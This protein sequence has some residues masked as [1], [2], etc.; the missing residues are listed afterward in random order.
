MKKDIREILNYDIIENVG[1][2]DIKFG[3]KEE[4]FLEIYSLGSDTSHIVKESG[5]W[6]FDDS[7]QVYFNQ[8]SSLS[9]ISL[10][11]NFKGKLNGKI[12][13]GSYFG[14]LRALRKDIDYC[15]DIEGY[16]VGTG[17]SRLQINFDENEYPGKVVDGEYIGPAYGHWYRDFHLGKIDHY[18]I[19]SISMEICDRNNPYDSDTWCYHIKDWVDPEEKYL[20]I[21]YF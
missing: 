9:Y 11:N 18:R 3:I 20:E 16:V 13:I 12:G 19:E 17:C 10:R 15:D 7:I 5:Y 1:I 6:F 21:R 2:G 14:E 4:E 8:Y